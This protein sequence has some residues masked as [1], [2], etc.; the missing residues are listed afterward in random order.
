M[1]TIESLTRLQRL[2][3]GELNREALSRRTLSRKIAYRVT[4]VTLQSLQERGLIKIRAV[5]NDSRG[6]IVWEIT[7]TGRAV[8]ERVA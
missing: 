3:L 4:W 2:T 6:D 5:K 1:K 8:L 7:D